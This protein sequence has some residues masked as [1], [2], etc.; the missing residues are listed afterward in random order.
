MS[1]PD[2]LISIA[3]VVLAAATGSLVG[4]FSAIFW[5]TFNADTTTFHPSGNYG[6][7]DTWYQIIFHDQTNF[8]G[9]NGTDMTLVLGGRPQNECQSIKNTKDVSEGRSATLFDQKNQDSYLPQGMKVT[10]YW[11]QDCKHYRPYGV[12]TVPAG[13]KK[14]EIPDI[15][16]PSANYEVFNNYSQQDGGDRQLGGHVMGV[17]WSLP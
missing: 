17:L 13:A 4:V 10:L 11:R 2:D 3:K 1:M 8:K 6:P 14:V 9:N 15:N 7:Q 16:K 12:I 5:A